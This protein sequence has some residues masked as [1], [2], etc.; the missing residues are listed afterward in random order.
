M[1][2]FLVKIA[3]K[4]RSFIPHF[5]FRLTRMPI[6]EAFFITPVLAFSYQDRM[7]VLL[8]GIFQ[9]QVEKTKQN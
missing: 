8:W 7:L 3:N 4:L 2:K 9:L 1:K 6:R 5:R